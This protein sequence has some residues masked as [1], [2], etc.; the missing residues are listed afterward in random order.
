MLRKMILC[1]AVLIPVGLCANDAEYFARGSHLEPLGEQDISVKSEV[2]SINLGDDGYA[3]VDV[4]YVFFNHGPAKTVTMG[5]EALMPYNTGDSITADAR[6]PYIND[7]TVVMN[8]KSLNYRNS[9]VQ[10]GSLDKPYDPSRDTLPEEAVR[11]AYAYCFDAHFVKGENKVHHT[12]RYNMSFG[13]GRA[14][15]VPYWLTP[16]SR[17]RGGKIGDF[18]LRIS[19]LNTAKHFVLSESLFH[20]S[21]FVITGG[22]GKIRRNKVYGEDVVEVALRNGTVEWHGRDFNP[23][24]DIEIIS[25]DIMTFFDESSPLGSFYDRGPYYVIS[26]D[27]EVDRRIA[28]NLPYASRGYVFKD[29]KLKRFFGKLWWYMPDPSWKPSTADFTPRELRLIN[30]G[31]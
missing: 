13:V 9:L 7:F 29:P 5:F 17:W 23:N 26:Y 8:D 10:P 24:D 21:R 6:H 14:F 16:A 12:Y 2:L 11:Y 3:T 20:G 22:K 27:R 19:A 31:K 25:A 30:E 4:Q 28:R 18:T 15:I 1:M